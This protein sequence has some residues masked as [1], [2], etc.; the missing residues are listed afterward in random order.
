MHAALKIAA[1]LAVLTLAAAA[2]AGC[3]VSP[4]PYY[5]D[6]AYYEQPSPVY[7]APRYYYGPR[8]NYWHHN[9]WHNRWHGNR[10][11]D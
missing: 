11:W 10:D 1:P 9:R 7:V 2:L 4:A 6:N 5:G 8:Y 3:V